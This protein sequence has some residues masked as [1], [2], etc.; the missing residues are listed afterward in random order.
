MSTLFNIDNFKSSNEFISIYILRLEHSKYYVGQAKDV[1][2]RL[3]Q[4]L[5]GKLSSEWTKLHK[6]INIFKQKKTEFKTVKNAIELENLTTIWCMRKFGWQNVRGGDFCTLN[7]NKLR[8]LLA[9]NSNLEE[10]ILPIKISTSGSIKR[11]KNY[12]FVLKLNNNNYFVSYTTNIYIAIMNEYNGLGSDWTKKYK[13]IELVSLHEVHDVSK[14]T[15][16]EL[17]NK[18]VEM[19]MKKFGFKNV[20]GGDFFNLDERKHKN[21]VLNY[22]NIFKK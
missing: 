20:R 19:N 9:L 13:P 6:P 10:E 5:S 16:R 7:L 1:Q 15:I 22:T 12:V 2:K 17:V 8:F 11:G 21:K 18:F 3:K 4:H 14:I